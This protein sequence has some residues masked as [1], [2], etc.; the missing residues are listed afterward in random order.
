MRFW[1]SKRA[2]VVGVH[3]DVLWLTGSLGSA[4]TG[5]RLCR[6]TSLELRREMTNLAAEE[7]TSTKRF[8]DMSHTFERSGRGRYE[9]LLKPYADTACHLLQLYGSR[10]TLPSLE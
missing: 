4:M 8:L 5:Q 1:R 9:E 3:V 6:D 2:A 7:G 10:M